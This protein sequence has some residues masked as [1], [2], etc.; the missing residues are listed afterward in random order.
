[1]YLFV[2]FIVFMIC[3]CVFACIGYS[4]WVSKMH[5]INQ[6][7]LSLRNFFMFLQ[8]PQLKKVGHSAN[9]SAKISKAVK[10]L[11][12]G[13]TNSGLQPR[14]Y[15]N[16]CIYVQKNE[17]KL[18]KLTTGSPVSPIAASHS[19]VGISWEPASP[20]SSCCARE[21]A[22]TSSAC[23]RPAKSLTVPLPKEAILVCMVRGFKEAS[24][25][26]V[27]TVGNLKEC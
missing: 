21:R 17:W 22:K 25:S 8:H 6:F 13:L 14:A 7:S 9:L 15:D 5:Y 4:I 11:V 26:E 2:A 1:M 3:F 18:Q 16:N 24:Q 12:C 20:R 27:N 10:T 23:A 19:G